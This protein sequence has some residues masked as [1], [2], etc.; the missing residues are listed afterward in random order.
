MDGWK[1]NE[2]ILYDN[3]PMSIILSENLLV[4][5]HFILVYIFVRY[6][7]S[8]NLLVNHQFILV[9]IFVRYKMSENLLVNHQFILVY[10]FVCCKI[11]RKN[12]GPFSLYQIMELFTLFKHWE[13]HQGEQEPRS[14][15]LASYV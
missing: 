4:N 8:E 3:K 10:I 2:N 15:P 1:R 7:M 13:T 11:L 12:L 5:H 6:K 9:Y 14:G